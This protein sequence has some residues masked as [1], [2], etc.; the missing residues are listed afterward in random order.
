MIKHVYLDKAKA[1]AVAEEMASQC[2]GVVSCLVWRGLITRKA[3]FDFVEDG[4]VLDSSVPDMLSGYEVLK[5]ATLTT[6]AKIAYLY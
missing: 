2:G 5:G 3:K 1:R 4:V 6:C